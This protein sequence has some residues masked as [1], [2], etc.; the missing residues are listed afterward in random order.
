MQTLTKILGAHKI[1]SKNNIC[2]R[3]S[4]N[5]KI[6]ALKVI[7]SITFWSTDFVFFPR[8]LRMSFFMKFYKHWE[9]LSMVAKNGVHLF[10]NLLFIPSSNELGSITWLSHSSVFSSVAELW[11][12]PN[13]ADIQNSKNIAFKVQNLLKQRN[14][15]KINLLEQK[16]VSNMRTTYENKRAHLS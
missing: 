11:T 15:R 8:L 6:S 16:K 3:R 4:K 13:S 9:L 7:F 5:N 1:S 2:R 12:K 10:S 14:I